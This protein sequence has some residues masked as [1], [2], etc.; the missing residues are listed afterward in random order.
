[1]AAGAAA[2]AARV[3]PEKPPFVPGSVP[4]FDDEST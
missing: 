4:P 2:V 3:T 1:R